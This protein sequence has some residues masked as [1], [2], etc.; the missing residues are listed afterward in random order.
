MDACTGG[1][2]AEAQ[3]DING[4]NVIDQNDL[5]NI[6]TEADPLWVAPTG[7]SF[8]GILHRPIILRLQDGEREMKVFS[9][10]AGT[11]DRVFEKSETMGVSS[12]R[13]IVD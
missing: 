2:L 12:W 11:T 13:E 6:G 3:F 1:R 7:K 5:I 4:D 8:T 10:S 9:T